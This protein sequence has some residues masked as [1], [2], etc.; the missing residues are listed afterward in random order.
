MWNDVRE[1]KG[2]KQKMFYVFGD[3]L[4]IHNQKIKLSEDLNKKIEQDYQ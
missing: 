3:P 4:I 1:A 2:F